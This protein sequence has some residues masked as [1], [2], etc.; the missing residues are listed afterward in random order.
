MNRSIIQLKFLV[1][2]C[3]AFGSLQ[4]QSKQ[5]KVSQSIKV[6]KNVTIDLNTSYCNIVFDT[7][8]RN[9][10]SIEAYVEGDNVSN[11]ALQGVLN[12]WDV[13]VDATNSHVSINAKSSGKPTKIWYATP[14]TYTDD[15]GLVNIILDELKYELA[16]LPDVICESISGIEIP[17]VPEIPALPEMPKMPKLPKL[18]KGADHVTF[19]YDA[20]KKDGEKYLE[21]YSKKFES[22]YGEEYAKKMEAWGEKF[23]KE[24]GEK[25]GKR[26]E[27]WAKNFENNWNSED[28]EKQ[29]EAW[30]ERFGQQME[31]QYKAREEAAKAR[32]KAHELREKARVKAME[33]REIQR[34]KRDQLIEKRRII[35]EKL[36]NKEGNIPVKKTIKIKMPK[37]AKLKV[38][39]RHGEVEFASA[40]NLNANLSHTKF[41]AQSVNGGSTSINAS[42]S[43]IYVT[44]WN[45]GELNLN[46]SKTVEIGNVKHVVLNAN[47]SNVTIDSLQGNAII[48]CNIGDVNIFKIDD[49]FTNL[50]VI[51]QNSNAL[52]A[53]PK[54]SCNLQYK[55]NKSRLSHPKKE[56]GNVTTF[57][58]G[59]LG[60]GK[61]IVVNAKYSTIIME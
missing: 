48:D 33:Q 3:F 49:S 27:A 12:N 16:D 52:I 7:W 42:Y 60:S 51:L 53:L 22:V 56:K 37:G 19:D 6:N 30:G 18:P 34:E 31:Q 23:G 54:A 61:S 1:I 13:D 55:G 4:A 2:L 45:L 14:N 40:E 43:P 20:Y 28:F 50:N 17:E 25:F 57:S 46:H 5:T 9:E 26:M 38:N 21:E 10:V 24:W 8:N 47:S 29:M 58:T 36:A 59:N 32:E 39:V 44:N 41:I 15:D 11:D 35:V